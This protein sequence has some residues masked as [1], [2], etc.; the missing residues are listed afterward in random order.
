MKIS[1]NILIQVLLYDEEIIKEMTD[2]ERRTLKT[3]RSYEEAFERLRQFQNPNKEKKSGIER[4]QQKIL[5]KVTSD[6]KKKTINQKWLISI[7]NELERLEHSLID[8]RNLYILHVRQMNFALKFYFEQFI[9]DLDKV[10]I[11]YLLQMYFLL[12]IFCSS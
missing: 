12:S 6:L 9:V 3:K 10:M 4:L 8:T 7:Q 11:N 2:V 5:P 1:V